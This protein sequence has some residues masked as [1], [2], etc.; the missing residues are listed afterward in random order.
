MT[1]S[2]RNS[3]TMTVSLNSAV[4]LF[5]CKAEQNLLVHVDGQR[6]LARVQSVVIKDGVRVAVTYGGMQFRLDTGLA[7]VPPGGFIVQVL[8]IPEARKMKCKW[9]YNE[10]PASNLRTRD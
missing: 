1:P 8:T 4:L 3:S 2:K 7:I 9:A 10:K 6:Y 5:P